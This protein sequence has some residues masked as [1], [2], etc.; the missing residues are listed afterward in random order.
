M[1]AVIDRKKRNNETDKNNKIKLL[2]RL[3]ENKKWGYK[4]NK[5]I[6]DSNGLKEVSGDTKREQTQFKNAAANYRT[7]Q[8]K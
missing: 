2:L 4:S 6:K 3:E 8:K 1:W 5:K 7:T